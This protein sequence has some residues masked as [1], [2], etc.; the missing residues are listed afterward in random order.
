MESVVDMSYTTF[1]VDT[2]VNTNSLNER[3]GAKET[4]LN[5]GE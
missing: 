1:A 4:E 5:P 2:L 3:D